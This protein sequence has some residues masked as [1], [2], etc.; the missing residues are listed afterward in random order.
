MWRRALLVN[1]WIGRI[2]VSVVEYSQMIGS[3]GAYLTGQGY[4]VEEV[5][6]FSRIEEIVAASEKAYLTPLVSPQKNDLT[7]G[8]CL[9]LVAWK[10]DVPVM[11]GGA[12]LEDLGL[13]SVSTFWPRSLERLY[14]RPKG[15]LIEAV[16]ETVGSVLRGRLAYFGD[17]HVSPQARGRNSL[18]SVR[19]FVT[20]GHLAVSLK[21]KPE[22]VYAFIREADALRGASLRYGFLDVYPQPMRWLDPPNPRTNSEWCCVTSREK[23]P[24]MARAAIQSLSA[25]GDQRS[26]DKRGVGKEAFIPLVV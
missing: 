15:E 13:E 4:R 17:L 12:R 22:F 8:N 16:C 20:L 21:W 3:C 18:K 9:W 2:A 25:Q 26:S 1:D 5:A 10:G 19:A 14:D 11:L 23:L 24:S 7:E 6:D